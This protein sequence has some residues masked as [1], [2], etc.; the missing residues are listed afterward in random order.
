MVCSVKQLKHS[1]IKHNNFNKS[2]S[3]TNHRYNSVSLKI[4]NQNS[5]VSKLTVC[6]VR[7][8]PCRHDH[9]LEFGA[10]G[11]HSKDGEGDV[12]ALDQHQAEHDQVDVVE[13]RRH[14]RARHLHVENGDTWL[15]S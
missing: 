5:F 14:R 15:V 8:T 10:R 12:G 11:E 7:C 3:F 4:N 6:K 1:K 13:Q 2:L 9:P